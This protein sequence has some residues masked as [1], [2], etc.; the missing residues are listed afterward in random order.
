MADGLDWGFEL[1]PDRKSG[2][3]KPAGFARVGRHT[4]GFQPGAIW[5]MRGMLRAG[6]SRGPDT[7]GTRPPTE[8]R[9]R[10]L[11]TVRL[12]PS[13]TIPRKLTGVLGFL[14]EALA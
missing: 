4:I 9:A 3:V 2:R 14:E 5:K 1:V 7:S 6:T 8:T 11:D 12:H 13:A 10:S